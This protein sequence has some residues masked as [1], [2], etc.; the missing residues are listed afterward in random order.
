MHRIF[1]FGIALF[2]ICL[3]PLG[4]TNPEDIEFRARV[5]KDTHA[6]HIGESIELEIVYSSQSEKKYQR[7]ST[8]SLESVNLR[9]TPSDGVVD[10][11]LMRWE[12]E[13]GWAGSIIGGLGY[14]GSKPVTQQLDL[15]AWYRF[16][17]P[18]HYSIIITSKEV[19]RLK[20]AEEGGGEEHLT[21]ESQPVEFDILPADPAWAAGELSN[22]D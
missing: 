11:R 21:L 6:Y 9:L 1:I 17:K 10:L 8:S 7:N 5:V 4:A 18:G 2:L 19:S 3:H 16:Y 13:D 12:G 14:L 15:C 22:I 20:S